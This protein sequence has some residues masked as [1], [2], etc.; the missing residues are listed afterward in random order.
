MLFIRKYYR[1]RGLFWWKWDKLFSSV[2]VCVMTGF[3]KDPV[4]LEK[5]IKFGSLFR[6]RGNGFL[7]KAVKYGQIL[8]PYLSC[9]VLTATAFDR[10]RAICYPLNY[11]SWSARK[12][13]AYV[14]YAWVV[15]MLFS[16]PQ[17]SD[18]NILFSGVI[19]ILS[20]LKNHLRIPHVIQCTSF[21]QYKRVILEDL[22][23]I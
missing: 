19:C 1:L 17:V 22:T 11:H 18:P 6:F 10:Y 5:R 15:S 23:L 9:Y 13:K 14:C 3:W 21:P 7:C 4:V 2:N 20:F 12:S 16:I 8:G